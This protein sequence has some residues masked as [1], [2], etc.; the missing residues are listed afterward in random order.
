MVVLDGGW[1]RVGRGEDADAP[2][3]LYYVAMTRA[4]LTLTLARLPG[5]HRLQDALLGTSSVLRRGEPSRIPQAAPELSRRYRRLGL[6]DV[7]LSFAGYMRPGHPVHRAISALSPSDPLRV[8][9]SSNRWDLLDRNGTVVG[10]L[11]GGFKMPDGMSC[12]FAIVHAVATWDRES[13]ETQYQDRL[14]CDA[15][16]VVVPELVL[17]PVS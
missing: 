13:S 4:R 8:R 2:R 1:D 17:E 10:R 15:W 5:P 14:R 11:A 16:E 6:R 3:R 7:V 12:A 9:S